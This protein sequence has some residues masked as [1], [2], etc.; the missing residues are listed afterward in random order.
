M[1]NK[2]K[3]RRGE[4]TDPGD[5]KAVGGAGGRARGKSQP[6]GTDDGFSTKGMFQSL[7]PFLFQKEAPTGGGK[8]TRK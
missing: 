6:Q 7:M 5:P 8:K 4:S 1:N 3:K 2:P